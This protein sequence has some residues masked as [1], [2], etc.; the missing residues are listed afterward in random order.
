MCILFYFLICPLIKTPINVLIE[1]SCLLTTIYQ[2]LIDVLIP[3]FTYMILTFFYLYDAD[4][5]HNR[6]LCIKIMDILD[7]KFCN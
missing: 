3:S 6:T 2:L 4:P 5:I 7:D 1:K